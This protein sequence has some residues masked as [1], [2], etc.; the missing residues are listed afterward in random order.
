MERRLE[1][2]DP[3]RNMYRWYAVAVSCDLFGAFTVERAWGRVG[4]RGRSKLD[5]YPTILAAKEAARR[6]YDVKR[7][8]GY[9]DAESAHGSSTGADERPARPPSITVSRP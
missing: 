6:L 3:V 2:I 8:R 5:G 4:A 9:I 1:R 7:R